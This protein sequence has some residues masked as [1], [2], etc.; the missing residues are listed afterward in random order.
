M[1]YVVSGTKKVGVDLNEDLVHSSGFCP[2]GGNEYRQD[3][4]CPTHGLFAMDHVRSYRRP[5][6]R[7][8]PSANLF[9]RRTLPSHGLCATDLAGKPARHRSQLVGASPQALPPGLPRAGSS[10]DSGRCQRNARLAKVRGVRSAVDR[11]GT[12]ALRAR[13][14]G[15]GTD[16]YRLCAGLDHARLVPVSI[17]L[18]L[19]PFHQVGGEN[20]HSA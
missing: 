6:R 17:S 19:V 13:G 20:A 10:L 18:G 14:L 1:I 15:S 7:Q 11:S 5:L 16:E 8:P 3:F 9:V 4:V 12:N 2:G